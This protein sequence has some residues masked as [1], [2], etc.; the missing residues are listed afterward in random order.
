M[1]IYFKNKN[2]RKREQIKQLNNRGE[3]VI[4]IH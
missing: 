3:K 2:K 4:S 1:T